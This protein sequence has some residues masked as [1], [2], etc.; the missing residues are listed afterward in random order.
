M[1]GFTSEQCAAAAS[2]SH[3][4]LEFPVMR[5]RVASRAGHILEAERKNFIGPTGSSHF[6]TIGARHRGVCPG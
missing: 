1:A 6:M 3:P 2:L 5:I 4:I